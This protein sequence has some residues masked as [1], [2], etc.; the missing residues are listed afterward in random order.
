MLK[1][2]DYMRLRRLGFNVK[3]SWGASQ[4]FTL[5][6]KSIASLWCLY[7]IYALLVFALSVN[8]SLIRKSE[9]TLV[10]TQLMY[11]NLIVNNN[12]LEYT[13]AELLNGQ[14]IKVDD[15]YYVFSKKVDNSIE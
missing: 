2:T 13:V 14:P 6:E 12:K 3:L 9:Y 10:K 8:N 1:L 11:H 5:I 7:V 15:A 4:N